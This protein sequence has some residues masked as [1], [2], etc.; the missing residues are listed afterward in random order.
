MWHNFVLQ[1]YCIDDAGLEE[2]KDIL[3]N[4]KCLNC[5]KTG[6]VKQQPS[7]Q[8]VSIIHLWLSMISKTKIFCNAE[9]FIDQFQSCS[10]L[11]TIV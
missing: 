2:C 1:V 3:E 4:V 9:S 5:H 8:V 7:A 11:I 6:F 10:D